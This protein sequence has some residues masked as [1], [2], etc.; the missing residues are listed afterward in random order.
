MSTLKFCGRDINRAFHVILS[1]PHCLSI[2][3]QHW[4][5]ALSL[6]NQARSLT[7][8]KLLRQISRS[9]NILLQYPCIRLSPHGTALLLTSN[10]QK[11]HRYSIPGNKGM[12]RAASL[13]PGGYLSV[14]LKRLSSLFEF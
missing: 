8:W 5:T 2:S 4:T 6:L 11:V 3:V 9:Y 12:L 1:F 7:P 13:D 10:D 14:A